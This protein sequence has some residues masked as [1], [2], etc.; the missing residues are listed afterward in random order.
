MKYRWSELN[1]TR[2]DSTDKIKL[3]L[4]QTWLLLLFFCLNRKGKFMCKVMK[5]LQETLE[6]SSSLRM[7]EQ[8]RSRGAQSETEGLHSLLQI[9]DQWPIR[10]R[11]NANSRTSWRI[12][13]TQRGWTSVQSRLSN[14]TVHRISISTTPSSQTLLPAEHCRPVYGR[15]H[16]SGTHGT[17]RVSNAPASLKTRTRKNVCKLY[18]VCLSGVFGWV[19]PYCPEYMM[20]FFGL[21]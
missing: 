5:R 2:T 18:L 16:G 19:V 6:G 1:C 15:F 3:W 7:K 11:E 20:V 17:H 14:L 8:L 9:T 13:R 21:K 10:Q 12:T 4:W